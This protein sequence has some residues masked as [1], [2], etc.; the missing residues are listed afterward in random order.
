MPLED[1]GDGV[2]LRYQQVF[3]GD[4][5]TLK[6]LKLIIFFVD[7][8]ESSSWTCRIKGCGGFHKSTFA[9]TVA[10]CIACR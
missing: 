7:F 8:P 1:T 5:F 9:E 4:W 10:N 6:K 3:I 2:T